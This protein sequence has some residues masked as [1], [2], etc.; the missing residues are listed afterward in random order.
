MLLLPTA[1]SPSCRVYKISTDVSVPNPLIKISTTSQSLGVLCHSFVVSQSYVSLTQVKYIFPTL[2][3][4]GF[5]KFELSVQILVLFYVNIYT[6]SVGSYF[7]PRSV[8][9]FAEVK[10]DREVQDRINGHSRKDTLEN[11]PP[12]CIVTLPMFWKIA[13]PLEAAAARTSRSRSIQSLT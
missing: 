4:R 12:P 8:F 10:F 9:F 13:N 7:K 3:T 1:V 5:L 2:I 11:L 6:S